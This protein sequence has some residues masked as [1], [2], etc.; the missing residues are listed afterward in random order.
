[1]EKDI[2]LF[3]TACFASKNDITIDEETQSLV[4]NKGTFHYP[5][6]SH[7]LRPPSRNRSKTFDIVVDYLNNQN[8]TTQQLKA[9][10]ISQK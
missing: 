3:H 1:M 5:R 10:P 7:P 6:S 4:K 2:H 9:N 8:F